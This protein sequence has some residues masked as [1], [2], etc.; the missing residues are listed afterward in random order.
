M[1]NLIL[2]GLI[3]IAIV[4]AL[5]AIFRISISVFAGIEID[6]I[7]YRPYGAVLWK[8]L[9][10]MFSAV[11]AFAGGMFAVS[12]HGE[13]KKTAIIFF[14]VLLVLLKYIQ[15]HFMISV[16]T[17]A[18]PVAALVFALLGVVLVWRMRV[19]H[20]EEQIIEE[21]SKKHHQ[22]DVDPW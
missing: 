8:L 13:K 21:P 1:K 6:I 15:V 22:P 20:K 3:G 5:D 18:Y 11:S 19:S 14:S 9:I 17:L 16:E 2:S 4:V 12:Y 10:V 7:Y